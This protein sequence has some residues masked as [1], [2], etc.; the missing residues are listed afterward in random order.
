VGTSLPELVFGLK[1]MGTSHKDEIIGNLLG[2]VV[3]NSTL[4]LGVTALLLPIQF[5]FIRGLSSIIFLM[6]V[7]LFFFVATYKG[8]INRLD[9][10]MLSLIYIVYAVVSG[11]LIL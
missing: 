5:E 6:L 4:V 8:R 2:S 1:A 3:V 10:L 9:A 11:Y 7:L